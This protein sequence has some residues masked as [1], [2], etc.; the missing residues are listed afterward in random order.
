LYG[1]LELY[2]GF[3]NRAGDN[4]AHFAHLGGM[5]FGLIFLLIWKKHKFNRWN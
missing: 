3:A 2:L 1:G 4:V 5:L